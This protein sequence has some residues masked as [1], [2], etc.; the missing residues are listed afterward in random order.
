V[1]A[2]Q[3]RFAWAIGFV[4]ALTML[5]LVVMKHVVGPIKKPD[6][7]RCLSDAAFL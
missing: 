6:R 5:Y 1:G 2:P 3:K 4:L 7:L